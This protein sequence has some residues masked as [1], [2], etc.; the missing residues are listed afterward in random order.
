MKK[1]VLTT[2]KDKLLNLAVGAGIPLGT[3]ASSTAGGCTG[4][5]GSCGATCLGGFALAAWRCGSVYF[6]RRRKSLAADGKP[7]SVQP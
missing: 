6:K 1:N 3:A 2:P 4:I 7:Q 5:C